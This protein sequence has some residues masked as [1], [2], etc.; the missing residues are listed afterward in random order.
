[1]QGQ[2]HQGCGK[3]EGHGNGTLVMD[4]VVF[5]GFLEDAVVTISDGVGL[6]STEAAID[7]VSVL[8]TDGQGLSRD[9]PED[10]FLAGRGRHGTLVLEV[11]HLIPNSE[12]FNKTLNWDVAKV[13]GDRLFSVPVTGYFVPDGGQL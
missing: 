10:T 11:G 2:A 5:V 6:H 12:G 7:E 3:S 9:S 4:F 8:G 1:M 13:K